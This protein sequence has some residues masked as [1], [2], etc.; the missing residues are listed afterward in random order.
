MTDKTFIKVLSDADK[1][2]YIDISTEVIKLL[3]EYD[4]QT[5]EIAYILEVLI[6]SLKET[7]DMGDVKIC[8]KN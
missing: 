3:N 4:L 8:Q 2:R 6:R 7:N 1:A 5:E